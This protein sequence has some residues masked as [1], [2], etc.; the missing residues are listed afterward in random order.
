MSFIA[1]K[2][3]Y[4]RL[5]VPLSASRPEIIKAFRRLA[6]IYHPDVS[7][8]PGLAHRVF[9]LI[10]EA[11]S[12]LSNEESRAQ[13]DACLKQ[14]LSRRPTAKEPAHNSQSTHQTGKTPTE[15]PKRTAKYGNFRRRTDLDIHTPLEIDL[16]TAV[17]GGPYMIHLSAY[18]GI[19]KIH[20]TTDIPIHLP[21]NMYSG[22]VITV[23]YRGDTDAGTGER[24]HLLLTVHYSKH[25]VFRVSGIDIYTAVDVMPWDWMLGGTL[26]VR[27]LEGTLNVAVPNGAHQWRRC[28]IEN[29]GLPAKTGGR[30][31]LILQMRLTVP[32]TCNH[33]QQLAWHRL[34]AAYS[35]QNSI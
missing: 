28:V 2:N 22:Q 20:S 21:K 23:P 4:E 32:K 9:P 26:Q 3:H 5:Q 12:T 25:S 1:S 8:D 19:K 27:T 6:M 17:N 29:A 13:Y 24:G 31:K 30:G 10:Y 15:N 35:H 16:E 14:A 11:Y 33:V 34:R 18:C 7:A